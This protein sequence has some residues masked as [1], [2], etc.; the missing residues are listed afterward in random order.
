M[1]FMILVLSYVGKSPLVFCLRSEVGDFLTYP[2]EYIISPCHPVNPK[3][4]LSYV[5]L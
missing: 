4:L 3:A 1:V 5:R 2:K